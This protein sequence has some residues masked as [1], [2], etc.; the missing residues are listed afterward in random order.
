MMRT[1]KLFNQD[2][3]D[4]FKF[5]ICQDT[6]VLNLYSGL[7][8]KFTKIHTL[9]HYSE[10][11]KLALNR[12][13][14]IYDFEATT[15]NKPD[16]NVDIPKDSV[17]MFLGAEDWYRILV[18][19]NQKQLTTVKVFVK[20][21]VNGSILAWQVMPPTNY[22][23]HALVYNFKG[24]WT[25]NFSATKNFTHHPLESVQVTPMTEQ[26]FSNPLN[27]TRID[28]LSSLFSTSI[29]PV[30]KSDTNQFIHVMTSYG[31]HIESVME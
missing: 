24:G 1:L 29:P 2:D 7:L 3:N 22:K 21:L 14:S 16:F 11:F 10:D 31:F 25:C 15:A 26:Y 9:R 4:I 8:V 6:S 27:P 12:N 28:I 18:D 19:G 20:F 13:Q 17:G 30:Y 5:D 23:N